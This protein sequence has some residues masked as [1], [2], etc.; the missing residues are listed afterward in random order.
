M[1]YLLNS[2]MKKIIKIHILHKFIITITLKIGNSPAARLENLSTEYAS[3]E[4][5]GESLTFDLHGMLKT[6]FSATP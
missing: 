1:V 3:T 4:I 5:N 2:A 6:I